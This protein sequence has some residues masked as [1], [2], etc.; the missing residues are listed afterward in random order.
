MRNISWLILKEMIQFPIIDPT[1]VKFKGNPK[2]IDLLGNLMLLL[3]AV[4]LTVPLN[5]RLLH[6]QDDEISHLMKNPY[7]ITPP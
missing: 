4:H 5:Y 1:T 3:C 2:S 7:P 6:T